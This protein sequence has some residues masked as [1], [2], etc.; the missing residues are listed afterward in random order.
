MLLRRPDTYPEAQPIN[1]DPWL[2]NIGDGPYYDQANLDV[3]ATS[4]EPELD[5]T[6]GFAHELQFDAFQQ[7][8]YTDYD[9]SSELSRSMFPYPAL[10]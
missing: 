7:V 1:L 10:V 8:P 5:L 4:F 9:F 6:Y 3:E 2:N